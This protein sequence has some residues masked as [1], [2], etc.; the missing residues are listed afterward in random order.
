VMNL[1]PW[2][3]Y[4]QDSLSITQ[5]AGRAARRSGRFREEKKS[6]APAGIRS[7]RPLRYARFSSA[8]L[9]TITRST[10]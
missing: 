4:S 6:L 1:T 3:L 9:Q 8:W 5:K 7:T 10:D 2:P